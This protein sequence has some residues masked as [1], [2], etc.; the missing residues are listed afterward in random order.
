MLVMV[1]S[2]AKR[3]LTE[4]GA[5]CGSSVEL[6]VPHR[7]HA[8]GPSRFVSLTGQGFPNCRCWPYF[9]L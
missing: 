4:R 3:F 7:L 2:F 1:V 6:Q 5:D 9:V 8:D